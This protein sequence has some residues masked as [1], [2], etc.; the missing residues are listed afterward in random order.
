MLSTAQIDL[1]D[2]SSHGARDRANLLDYGL[3]RHSWLAFILPRRGEEEK[4]LLKLDEIKWTRLKNGSALLVLVP[5]IRSVSSDQ[6][7][8]QYGHILRFALEIS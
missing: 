8:R 7:F 4:R 2:L 1:R 3:T 5:G 6:A